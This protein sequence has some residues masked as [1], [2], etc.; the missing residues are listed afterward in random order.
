MR[1][2][3]VWA[4]SE[5]TLL[6][7]EC[8]QETPVTYRYAGVTS[9]LVEMPDVGVWLIPPGRPEFAAQLNMAEYPEW[10]RP[11]QESVTDIPGRPNS[12][13]VQTARR[14]SRR[15]SLK[16]WARNLDLFA[17][18]D[19]CLEVTGPKL[20]SSPVRHHPLEQRGLWVTVG[21]VGETFPGVQGVPIWLLTLPLTRVDRPE[22]VAIEA[23]HRIMDE[24]GTWLE[25]TGLLGDP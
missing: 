4:D 11:I 2:T 10:L 3:A 22:V 20:L 16:V 7:F 24:V 6:D 17:T 13:V 19:A 21:D 8:P 18:L 5:W 14:G 23:G 15:G 12:V 9:A 1:G 25:A